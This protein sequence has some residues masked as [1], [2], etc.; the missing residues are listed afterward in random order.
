MLTTVIPQRQHL[1]DTTESFMVLIKETHEVIKGALVCNIVLQNS[2]CVCVSRAQN[3]HLSPEQVKP[4][5]RQA[6]R[7]LCLSLGQM[8]TLSCYWIEV[9]FM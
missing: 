9:I 7:S 1:S 5:I 4:G 6:S 2:V 3:D 8:M